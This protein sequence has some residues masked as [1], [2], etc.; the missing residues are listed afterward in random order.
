MPQ[1]PDP[2]R[3]TEYSHP[4]RLRNMHRLGHG[5]NEPARS[6]AAGSHMEGKGEE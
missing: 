6:Y 4:P 3:A 5:I 2:K 1:Y